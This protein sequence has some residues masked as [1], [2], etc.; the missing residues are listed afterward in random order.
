VHPIFD[1]IELIAAHSEVCS[2]RCS[3]TIRTAR[4]RTCGEHLV[5]LV[6]APSSQGLEPPANPVRF[7]IFRCRV[8]Q[9]LRDS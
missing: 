6:I 3:N 2:P 5:C 7:K 9:P 1:A 8:A 4:D